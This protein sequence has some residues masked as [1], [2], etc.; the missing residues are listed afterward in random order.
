MPSASSASAKRTRAESGSTSERKPLT[1]EEGE[2]RELTLEDLKHF[3]PA[4]EVL[5]PEL[6]A[7][8]EALR[9]SRAAR[10]KERATIPLSRDV[11][12]RFRATGKGWQARVD[13]ALREW[14][15]T[16]SLE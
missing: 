3:R 7:K 6:L 16:H 9:I 12:D 8:W 15:D 4:K 5:S 10:V 13:A 2:V 11:L 1:N 14:L